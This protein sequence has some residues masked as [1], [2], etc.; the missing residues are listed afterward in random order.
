MQQKTNEFNEAAASLTKRTKKD[1]AAIGTDTLPKGKAAVAAANK[2]V[3]RIKG[4]S[5]KYQEQ[6]TKAKSISFDWAR[7]ARDVAAVGE[8]VNKQSLGALNDVVAN[9]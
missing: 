4:I 3:A 6:H 1:V 7:L 8:K 9:A 2:G 5:K